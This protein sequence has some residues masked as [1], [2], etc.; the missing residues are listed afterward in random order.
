MSLQNSV[1]LP[2]CASHLLN[3]GAVS[4]PALFAF[5]LSPAFGAAFAPALVATAKVFAVG[6]AGFWAV[7]RGWVKAE[8]LVPIGQLIATL[9]LPCLIFHRF[10]VQFDPQKFPGWPKLMLMSAGITLFGLLLG[11][12]IARRHGNEE[13]TLLVGYQNAGFFVLPMLQALLPAQQF[14]RAALMLFVFVI[15][16]NASLWPAGSWFLLRKRE[17]NWRSLLSPPTITT[18][19]ALTIYGLFH[20]AAHRLD[21]TGISDIFLGGQTP[22]ALQ[23]IG[24][25]TVP[26]AT[27]V[28]GGS[29]AAT[30]RGSLAQVPFKRAA[31]EVAIVKLVVVPFAGYCVLRFWPGGGFEANRTLWLLLMLE[32]AAPP[33]MNIAVFCQQQNFP[34]RLIPAACLVCYLLSLVTVPLWVALVPLKP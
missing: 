16:F 25:L 34:M 11:K 9:T 4:P 17:L 13:A 5:A 29:I 8:G 33:A 10:A 32:F 18:V 31:L 30:L 3:C 28:L 1:L 22:G 20:D 21:G 14:D 7:R 26:L 23:L 6:M 2:G 24:D 12:I 19:V 15:P 27:L